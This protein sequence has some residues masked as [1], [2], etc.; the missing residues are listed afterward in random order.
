M[1]RPVSPVPF[2]VRPQ[3][4]YVEGAPIVVCRAW[5][6]GDERH[7]RRGV[8]CMV[9]HCPHTVAVTDYQL[10]TGYLCLADAESYG[11]LPPG[12]AAADAREAG[13]S[14]A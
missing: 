8:A 1:A 14:L 12:T 5:R 13:R 10:G 6:F 3:G 2:P 9:D 4:G 11:L 7:G